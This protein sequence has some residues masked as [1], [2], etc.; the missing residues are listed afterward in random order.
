MNSSL[1]TSCL[2][3][4]Y[5]KTSVFLMAVG[6]CLAHVVWEVS[7]DDLKELT[8]K[9]NSGLEG[10]QPAVITFHDITAKVVSDRST[11]SSFEVD[12]NLED[13][14]GYIALPKAGR[15]YFAELGFKT[16]DG[17]VLI[18]ESNSVETPRDTPVKKLSFKNEFKSNERAKAK[19]VSI[20]EQVPCENLAS[21]ES[22]AEKGRE[23]TLPLVNRVRFGEGAI[24]KYIA[25]I[26]VL[27]NPASRLSILPNMDMEPSFWLQVNA[28]YGYSRLDKNVQGVDLTQLSEEKFITGISST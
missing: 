21:E 9:C 10:S 5:D 13:K 6:P 3:D 23:V 17:F 16:E 4:L 11:H 22:T 19:A 28:S 24:N 1:E 27:N 20:D 8:K 26:D 2:P 25:A 14:K 12:I 15:T 7:A 18:A